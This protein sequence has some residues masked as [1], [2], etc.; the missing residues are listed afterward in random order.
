MRIATILRVLIM[1]FT[2]VGCVSSSYNNI[3]VEP[4]E[5]SIPTPASAAAAI[6][7]INSNNSSEQIVGMWAIL[8]YPESIDNAQPLVIDNLSDP[9][10]DVRINAAKVLGEFGPSAN[11]A[12]PDL[13]RAMKNDS[14][15]AVKI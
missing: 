12:V 9:V 1:S 7:Y 14:S 11:M 6:A 4:A 10:S 2:M 5:T 8:D 13:V 3:S 15:E